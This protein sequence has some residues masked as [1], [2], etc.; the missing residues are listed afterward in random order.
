MLRLVY[1]SGGVSLVKVTTSIIEINN[2]RVRSRTTL[3]MSY[4]RI[5]YQYNT[6]PV[7]SEGLVRRTY[8]MIYLIHSHIN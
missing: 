1:G 8:F 4:V 6:A 3:I 7:T 2:L 5:F